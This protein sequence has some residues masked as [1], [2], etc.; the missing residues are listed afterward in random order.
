MQLSAFVNENEGQ[1][2]WHGYLPRETAAV[3]HSVT[4]HSLQLPLVASSVPRDLQKICHIINGTRTQ[5]FSTSLL[6]VQLNIHYD[7]CCS[8][9]K[10][11]QL[12]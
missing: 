6:C 8:G 3:S 11:R 12:K 2:H 1:R 5:N 9:C 4:F 10:T 7:Q